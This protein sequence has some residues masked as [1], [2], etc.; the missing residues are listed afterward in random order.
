MDLFDQVN[1]GGKVVAVAFD[2]GVAAEGSPRV[3]FVWTILLDEEIS[4]ED[5]SLPILE[6]AA[7]GSEERGCNNLLVE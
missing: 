5:F 4:I 3:T 2:E 6:G 7:V 1:Q